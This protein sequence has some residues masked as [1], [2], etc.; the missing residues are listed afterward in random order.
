MKILHCAD[1]HL[2]SNMTSNLTKEK[3]KERKNELL[4]TFNRMI[5]YALDNDIRAILI[6]GDLFDKKKVSRTALSIVRQAIDMH[7]QIEF[8][9]LKG[10]HDVDSLLGDMEEIPDNLKLFGDSWT[11]YELEGENGL[12][13]TINGMELNADNSGSAYDSLVLNYDCFNIVMLHGQEAEHTSKDKTEVINIRR[14][15]NKGIDYLALGHIHSYKEEPL[16]ARGT[17]CYSGCLEGRGFDECGEHGF[18]IINIDEEKRRSTRTFVPIAKR[19]IYTVDIDVTGCNTTMDIISRIDTELSENIY[20]ESSLMKFILVGEVDVEC[21]KDLAYLLKQ[22]EDRFYFLKIYDETGL[23]VDYDEFAHDVSLKG[24]FVRT[25]K[26]ADDLSEEEKADII[27]C[28]IR[29]L[30]GEEV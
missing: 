27:R 2:D 22:Y 20:P 26:Q 1:L 15:K 5:Q 23:H 10:N 12:R 11:S 21:E 3:A 7:P 24:E 4:M 14:L 28:G 29:L 8:F 17:Y 6:A 19:N 18:V 13:V 30:A 25:L 9:Y 16:D